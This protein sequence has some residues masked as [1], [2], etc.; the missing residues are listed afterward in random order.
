[1]VF[2]TEMPEILS[3]FSMEKSVQLSKGTTPKE[4]PFGN[5]RNT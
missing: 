1:M 2:G 3:F 5:Y 4:I